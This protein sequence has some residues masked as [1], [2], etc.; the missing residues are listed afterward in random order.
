LIATVPREPP[1]MLEGPKA[2]SLVAQ[3]FS[4]MKPMLSVVL[5]VGFTR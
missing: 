4:R 3:F 1:G 2:C 5:S